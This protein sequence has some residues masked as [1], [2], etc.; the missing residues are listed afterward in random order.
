[1]RE[2]ILM[3]NKIVVENIDIENIEKVKRSLNSKE[4]ESSNEKHRT[5]ENE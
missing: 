4:N 2:A 5:L 1:M 3:R